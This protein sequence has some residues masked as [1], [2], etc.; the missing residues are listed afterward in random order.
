M[1]TANRISVT[2]NESSSSTT[3]TS[4]SIVN[5]YN[6]FVIFSVILGLYINNKEHQISIRERAIIK[7]S[8]IHLHYNDSDTLLLNDSN[9]SNAFNS[10][11]NNDNKKRIKE[12]LIRGYTYII[13]L[14]HLYSMLSFLVYAASYPLCCNK[15]D[16]L[17]ASTNITSLVYNGTI[18]TILDFIFL[19]RGNETSGAFHQFFNTLYEINLLAVLIIQVYI[20]HST[21]KNALGAVVFQ[22]LLSIPFFIYSGYNKSGEL[23][24]LYAMSS[25]Y[26]YK[27]Q[28]QNEGTKI[29]N[30]ILLVLMG[31]IWGCQLPI[32]FANIIYAIIGLSRLNGDHLVLT[33]GTS[34]YDLDS[35][36]INDDDAN[37]PYS[38]TGL[39]STYDGGSISSYC[40]AGACCIWSV[41]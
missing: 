7:K 37:C 23:H 35:W 22:S 39:S 11:D 2:I 21:S 27:R 38:F 36:I 14:S 18:V 25:S 9:D 30:I 28:F 3:T 20:F 12:L 4:L 15:A 29:C 6:D 10:N 31:F 40:G 5:N 32:S 24:K 33:Y 41:Y 16:V 1:A 19:L 34:I 8:L 13:L 26:V 17:V